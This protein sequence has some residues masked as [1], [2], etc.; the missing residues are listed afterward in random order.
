MLVNPTWDSRF[1]WAIGVLTICA[2]I[3]LLRRLT[4]SRRDLETS[5]VELALQSELRTQEAN[6]RIAAEER[7]RLAR[8]LHDVVAHEMSM[9]VV[10]AQSAPYRLKNVTPAVHAEFDAI[11]ETARKALD[12]VRGMLGVLRSDA[13]ALATTPIGASQILPT[14][15]NARRSGVDIAWTINGD[16]NNVDEA[17]GVVLHRVLQ[18]S[19]SNA[20]RHAPGGAVLVTADLEARDSRDNPLA[21]LQ[22]T[23]SPAANGELPTPESTG[24]SGI[25]GMAT[26]VRAVGGAF[27]ATPE[28]DG[29]FT[30]T[31]EI[32]LK[33]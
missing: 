8:D 2:F 14:L 24:G 32:P 33:R 31:A 21:Y 7:T 9:V 4:S 16:L 27:S 26:R 28:S 1:G 11:A 18:E 12:E 20:S 5:A 10:Q 29:G 6:R 13:E 23:N 15:Q 22:I 17:T 30:V 25:K 19:L 3:L